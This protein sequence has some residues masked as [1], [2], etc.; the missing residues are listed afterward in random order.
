MSFLN[1]AST[2]NALRDTTSNGGESGVNTLITSRS[3]LPTV[4]DPGF[5]RFLNLLSLSK[6]GYENSSL[7][8]RLSIV[9]AY[10]RGDVKSTI[11]TRS[12][13]ADEVAVV[14]PVTTT[15]VIALP[16]DY[17]VYARMTRQSDYKDLKQLLYFKPFTRQRAKLP[18]RE[19]VSDFIDDLTSKQLLWL[20]RLYFHCKLNPP[21]QTQAEISASFAR[22]GSG[23]DVEEDDEDDS[24]EEMKFGG[25]SE[26][27]ESYVKPQPITF[28]FLFM[29][30]LNNQ[31]L[32][33]FLTYLDGL[34]REEALTPVTLRSGLYVLTSI[35][36][37]LGGGKHLSNFSGQTLLL[38]KD[39]LRQLEDTTQR[40]NEK[41]TIQKNK[42]ETNRIRDASLELP[43]RQFMEYIYYFCK[44][45]IIIYIYGL[46]ILDMCVI[47]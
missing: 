17:E 30:V 43:A 7:T 5:T 35:I 28:D 11:T 38:A 45:I 25:S 36:Y 19:I 37:Q 44:L 12:E 26:S 27:V 23:S 15:P 46:F 14:P 22:G 41:C 13:P 21:F 39:S 20:T 31:T 33:S 24:D 18:T 10:Q 2:S 42:S 40:F 4:N 34:P 3:G 1:T 8:E 9:E 47:E 16:G 29:N 6:S 32:R